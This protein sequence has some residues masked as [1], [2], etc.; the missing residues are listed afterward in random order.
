[1]VVGTDST[2]NHTFTLD[3]TYSITLNVADGCGNVYTS[4][5]TVNVLNTSLSTLR[6]AKISVY[7]SPANQYVNVSGL[8]GVAQIEIATVNGQAVKQVSNDFDKVKVFQIN[9]SELVNGVYFIKTVTTQG[10]KVV[11]FD[12]AR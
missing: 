3:A 7:P 4:S 2:L 1:V 10:V 12:V 8:T 9:T 6:T 11:K 5:Q